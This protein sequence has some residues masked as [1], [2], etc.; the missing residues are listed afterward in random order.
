MTRSGQHRT[1]AV[2]GA[3]PRDPVGTLHCSKPGAF[4][5]RKLFKSSAKN[6]LAY[7]ISKGDIFIEAFFR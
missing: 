1:I 5:E 3:R 6:T 2:A 4:L 7:D